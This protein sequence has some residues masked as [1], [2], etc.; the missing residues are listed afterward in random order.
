MPIRSFLCLNRR[1]LTEFDS[2]YLNP[3]K[4]PRCSGPK[5][6]WLPK[7]VGILSGPTKKADQTIK[8]LA[9]DFGMTNV[10]T[11]RAGERAMPRPSQ[12]NVVD[13]RMK[14]APAWGGKFLIG[15]DGKPWSMCV[16]TGVTGKMKGT[17]IINQR[18]RYT[19]NQDLGGGSQIE[20]RWGTQADINAAVEKLK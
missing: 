15:P 1:C 7:P 6:Q 13:F 10:N 3:S 20:N 17:N 8:D 11:P 16:P 4:C 2:P 18:A 19:P 5:V 9:A 14:N 12:G